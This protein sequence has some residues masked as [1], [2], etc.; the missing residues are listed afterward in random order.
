MN[1]PTLDIK[2]T[3]NT[4]AVLLDID[5]NAFILVGNSIP[6]N[7]GEFYGPIIDKVKLSIPAMAD[8]A[9][10]TICLPYFNSSSLKAVY[11]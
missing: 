6:E 2:A 9:T 5:K 10:F 7:A 1:N 3:R 8:G 11:L 4:P